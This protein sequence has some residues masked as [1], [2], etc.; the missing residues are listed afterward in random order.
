MYKVQCNSS[1]SLSLTAL[2]TFSFPGQIPISHL[3]SYGY[4]IS[5]LICNFIQKLFH[6]FIQISHI[7]TILLLLKSTIQNLFINSSMFLLFYFVTS[8]YFTLSEYV[9]LYFTQCAYLSLYFLIFSIIF[10]PFPICRQLYTVKEYIPYD[11]IISQD[12]Q[13]HLPPPIHLL[14]K[15]S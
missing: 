12:R 14:F 1:Q 9:S 5:H 11:V 13:A 7:L 2:H 8:I 6:L 15:N 4:F 10:I 3:S